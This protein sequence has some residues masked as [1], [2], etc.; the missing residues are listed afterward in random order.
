MADKPVISNECT[1][2]ATTRSKEQSMKENMIN[3]IKKNNMHD[4]KANLNFSM[5]RLNYKSKK[6]KRKKEN[7]E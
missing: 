7:L 3:K 1:Y 5:I 2:R 6:E 4:R